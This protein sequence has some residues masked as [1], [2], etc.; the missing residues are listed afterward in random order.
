MWKEIVMVYEEAQW[1]FT[2][3]TEENYD[4]PLVR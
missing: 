4:K 1:N 2:G 3:R